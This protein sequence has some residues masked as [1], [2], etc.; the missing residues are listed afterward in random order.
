MSSNKVKKLRQELKTLWSRGGVKPRDIQSFAKRL[1]LRIVR[2][3][4]HP[5]WG[6]P[7]NKV[8]DGLD[9]FPVPDH[10]RDYAKGTRD[11]LLNS[12]DEYLSRL[13]KGESYELGKKEENESD[14]EI[15]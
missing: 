11:S 14:E 3:N 10:S 6:A 4:R 7:E 5:V 12:L 1:G 2:S 9:L 8:F 15:N 13:E